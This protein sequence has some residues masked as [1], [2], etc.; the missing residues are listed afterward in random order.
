MDFITIFNCSYNQLI[1]AQFGSPIFLETGFK[2]LKGLKKIIFSIS[3][4][5]Q[6][7]HSHL[8]SLLVRA[9]SMTRTSLVVHQTIRIL[10]EVVRLHLTKMMICTS[11]GLTLLY[12]SPLGLPTCLFCR[13]YILWVLEVALE[14]LGPREMQMF[15][16][17]AIWNPCWTPDCLQKRGLPHPKKCPLCD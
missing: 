4:T 7:K 15:I 11:G 3:F 17:L 16:W 5:L 6:S 12:S 2:N 13:L 10:A 8:S 14:M 1:K 9:N